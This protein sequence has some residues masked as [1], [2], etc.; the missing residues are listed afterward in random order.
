MN[1]NTLK[2]MSSTALAEAKSKADAAYAEHVR[3]FGNCNV[4]K[5]LNDERTKPLLDA[6]NRF[7][8]ETQRRAARS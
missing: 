4:Y 7:F 6:A 2:R 5:V 1:T 3:S 8:H